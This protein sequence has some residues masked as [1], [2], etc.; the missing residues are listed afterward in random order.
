M[1]AA[2]LLRLAE[3][4]PTIKYYTNKETREQIVSGLGE[5]HIDVVKSKLNSP[6]TTVE[7][8]MLS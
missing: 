5:Q 8:S 3:E 1:K 4:D 6:A 2:G 7:F